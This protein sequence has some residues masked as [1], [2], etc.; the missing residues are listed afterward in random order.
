MNQGVFYPDFD[1]E[2]ELCGGSPCVL[3]RGDTT[4]HATVCGPHF[5]KDRLMSDCDLWNEPQEDTE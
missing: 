3:I 2:C 5:F 4:Y 1:A